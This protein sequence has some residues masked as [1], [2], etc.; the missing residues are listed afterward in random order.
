VNTL[1]LKAAIAQAHVAVERGESGARDELERLQAEFRLGGHAIIR[2]PSSATA[3]LTDP[4]TPRRRKRTTPT[5]SDRAYGI[6]YEEVELRET[7]VDYKVG[8]SPNAR[9]DILDEIRR[10][11]REAGQE[12]EV[13]GWLF[14]PHRPRADLNWIN[15]VKVVT[16]PR[17][18]RSSVMLGDPL[19]ALGVVRDAGLKHLH[20]L[21]CWHSHSEGGSEL[22]SLQDAKAWAGTMDGLGR[23][24]YVAL[25]VSPSPNVRWMVPRFSAWVAGRYGVP[26][27]P[28]VGRAR[29]EW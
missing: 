1:D 27:Q 11:H 17:G 13:G 23:Q 12:I 5:A 24:A 19:D 7:F 20:V 28:V 14:G 18:S 4:R 21:G 10:A 6:S 25:I 9:E 3:R 22:P 29:L 2:T 15:I 8:L 26:S 16:G